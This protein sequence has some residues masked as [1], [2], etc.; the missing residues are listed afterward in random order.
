MRVTLDDLPSLAL[1]A[2]VVERRSFSAAARE[3]GIAKSAV[4]R[5][6][7]ELERKLGVRLLQRTTRALSVTDEGLAV[8]E[9]CA[10]LVGAAHAVE[11]VVSGSTGV[12][13]GTLHVGAPVT[14]AQMYLA[15]A[16]AGFLREHPA[17]KVRLTTD[18]RVVDVVEGGYDVIVRIGRLADTSLHAKKLAED[19]LVVCGSPEYLERAGSPESP[20]DLLQHNCFHYDLVSFGAEWRFKRRGAPFARPVPGNFTADDGT[21][22]REAALAGLGLAVVPSFMVTRDVAEGRLRLVLEGARRARIGIFAMTAH[23][24]HP[25]P[26]VRAFLGFLARYFSGRSFRS[27]A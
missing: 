27:V 14:F 25:P 4:S 20:G 23:G 7:A 24:A 15:S 21:L 3:A 17:V 8:Y 18:N 13:R 10:V 2:G 16:V 11:D 9:Q 1:F 26:R 12:V 5:R 19:R 6:I 22:L